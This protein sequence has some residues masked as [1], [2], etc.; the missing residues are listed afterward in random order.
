MTV[1]HLRQAARPRSGA[2]QT[3]ASTKFDQPQH[4][5]AARSLG[6]A[7]TLG[8]FDAWEGTSAIWAARLTLQEKAALAFSALRALD[9]ETAE[10]TATAALYG[11]QAGM[12]MAILCSPMTEASFWADCA[13]TAELDAYA[14]ACFNRM[15]PLR[16]SAFLSFV[17]RRAAA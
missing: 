8:D 17:Q 6:Y 9:L 10:L 15:A 2:T 13:S 16:Q 4:K 1:H 14:L 11:S 5:A 3:S 7:L 12:P